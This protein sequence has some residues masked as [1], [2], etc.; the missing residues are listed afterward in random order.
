MLLQASCRGSFNARKENSFASKSRKWSAVSPSKRESRRHRDRMPSS[1]CEC[2]RNKR[3]WKSE[4]K[5]AHCDSATESPVI[6]SRRC[7]AHPQSAFTV[8]GRS[9]RQDQQTLLVICLHSAAISRWAIVASANA[10]W[11]S[12]KSRGEVWL[13]FIPPRDVEIYGIVLR[14]GKMTFFF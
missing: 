14:K 3:V 8:N 9:R 11:N 12:C 7:W 4:L 6:Q 5:T 2:S 10:Y 1:R 13:S